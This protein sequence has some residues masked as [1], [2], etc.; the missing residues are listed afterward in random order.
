MT[1]TT[2]CCVVAFTALSGQ[3][4]EGWQG[5][6]PLTLLPSMSYTQDAVECAKLC[7]SALG[8]T[9]D[10]VLLQVGEG[11]GLRGKLEQS[12]AWWWGSLAI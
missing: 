2:I 11:G 10:D 6:Q 9:P 1:L 12:A 3:A 8:V 7:A 5:R 4:S